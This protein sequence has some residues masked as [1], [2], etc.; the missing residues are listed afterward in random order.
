M[1]LEH[2]RRQELDSAEQCFAR[3]L[4]KLPDNVQ[5]V[6][7]LDLS[8]AERAAVP[9]VVEAIGDFKPG[10]RTARRHGLKPAL[11]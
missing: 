9:D 4:G 5:A 1:A 3:L 7:F 2:V 10:L 11:G 6:R 8:E